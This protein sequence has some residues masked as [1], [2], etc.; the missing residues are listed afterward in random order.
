MV[1]TLLLQNNSI[2]SISAILEKSSKSIYNT[3]S[4]IKR[5]INIPLPT[6]SC[7]LGC[8]FKITKRTKRAINRNLSRSS[9]KN[10]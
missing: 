7:K 8:S 1:S 2:T 3:I 5:K 9:K 10:K 4:C 6:I